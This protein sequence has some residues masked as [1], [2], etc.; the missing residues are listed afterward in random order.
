MSEG[1]YLI[2]MWYKRSE[3][4]KRFTLF[5]GS[6]QLAGAFGGLLASAIGKMNGIRGFR[7]WRWIFILEG[8]LTCVVALAAFFIIPD[9]PEKARWLQED[10]RAYL[11][12]RL[13]AEQG[14]P[15]AESRITLKDILRVFKDY[16]VF[17]GGLMYFCLIVPAYG[18]CP[19]SLENLYQE[20]TYSHLWVQASPTFLP[21]SSRHIAIRPSKRNFVPYPRVPRPLCSP[22][23]SHIC[24]TASGTAFFSP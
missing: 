2:G 21:P 12:A 24:P 1:F 19:L 22:S 13:E 15:A 11:R 4:Q 17:L 10:E 3:A 7:A 9:F 16:K 8:I 5:F 6:T 18:M 20:F 23:S 14:D